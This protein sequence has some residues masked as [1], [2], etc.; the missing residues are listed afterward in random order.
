MARKLRNHGILLIFSKC[1]FLMIFETLCKYTDP[2]LLWYQNTSEYRLE[3]QSPWIMLHHCYYTTRYLWS[4]V[5]MIFWDKS[6]DRNRG[7]RLEPKKLAVS[8]IIFQNLYSKKQYFKMTLVN[9][10]SLLFYLQYTSM[11]FNVHF[12]QQHQDNCILYTHTLL[13]ILILLCC[14]SILTLLYRVS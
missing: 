8:I 12:V 9:T 10:A 4:Q 14:I 11:Y 6:L 1:Q 3:Y 5:K 2:S 13:S 7:A